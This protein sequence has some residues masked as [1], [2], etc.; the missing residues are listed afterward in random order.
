MTRGSDMLRADPEPGSSLT[1]SA[2]QAS[3][4]PRTFAPSHESSR[5]RRPQ[6]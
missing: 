6:R 3:D 5:P 2:P 4:K 1:P